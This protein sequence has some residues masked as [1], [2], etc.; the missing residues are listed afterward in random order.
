MRILWC[1]VIWC[2]DEWYAVLLLPV[3]NCW[4]D[5]CQ[6]SARAL[7]PQPAP[8]APSP[9]PHAFSSWEDDGL[10]LQRNPPRKKI[11]WLLTRAFPPPPHTHTVVMGG[12]GGPHAC[13]LV[14]HGGVPRPAGV[15]VPSLCLSPRFLLLRT[16][17]GSGLP[18]GSASGAPPPDIWFIPFLVR[19]AVALRIHCCRS[20][21]WF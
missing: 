16:A 19:F 8:S 1:A 9:R 11:V 18:P 15:S 14:A 3:V 13:H 12:R 6:S 21:W 4:C 17:P 5:I 2:T 10:W 7:S 20:P